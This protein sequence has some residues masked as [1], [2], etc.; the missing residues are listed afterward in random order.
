MLTVLSFI[1]VLG[2]LIFVHEL[3]HF[4]LAKKVGIRVDQFS[5]GFPPHIFSKQ[6]GETK[7]CIGLIPLGGYVK[8]AGENPD[9]AATGAPHEFMSKPVGHR[10]LVILAGPAM[11]YLLAIVLLIGVYL[12]SGEPVYDNNR[13][14]VGEMTANGPAANAG[15]QTGDQILAI[16]GEYHSNFD[17]V[18]VRIYRIVEGPVEVTWLHDSDTLTATITTRLSE[19]PNIQG[20]IDTVGLI[21][22][23]QQ[24]LEYRQFGIGEAIA[25]GF[26]SAH[27]FVY[28][29]V[30]FVKMLVAGEVS[31]KMLGGPLFIAQQSGK[32]ARKGA[33][34]LFVFMALLSVNL[35]VLNIL[36]IPVLD[37]GH[38]VFLG[39]EAVRGS[40]LSM[41]ARLMA[42]QVGLISLLGLIIF[43]TYNDIL[44]VLNRF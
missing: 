14:L 12:F 11:N 24:V 5:L 35:A 18:R 29:T 19:L 44:R 22:F 21:G 15:I 34:N 39:I 23:Q 25:N 40:P 2:V 28:Q 6:R 38:M 30:R 41:R 43:V 3:G 37:G 13:V 9:E 4:L 20:G 36:P 27:V 10:S 1:F 33:A 32:E 16:N 7:Y 8:M 42:Q 31:T 17:S 26:I